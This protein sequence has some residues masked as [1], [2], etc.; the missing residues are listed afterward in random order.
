MYDWYV[1]KQALSISIVINQS[2]H[3]QEVN[4]MEK[5]DSFAL[6]NNKNNSLVNVSEIFVANQYEIYLNLSDDLLAL[7][8]ARVALSLVFLY[9]IW[10]INKLLEPLMNAVQQIL[11]QQDSWNPTVA[12]FTIIAF[13]LNAV[14]ILYP[15]IEI[16]RSNFLSFANGPLFIIV[17]K[18][19]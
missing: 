9:T 1:Y 15:S 17:T 13:A 11:G 16:Y 8:L 5:V 14:E 2:Q 12:K 3:S 10:G 4:G 18:I 7:W 19:E 6:N